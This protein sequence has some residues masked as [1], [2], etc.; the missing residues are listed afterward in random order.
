M[1]SWTQTDTVTGPA[2]LPRTIL[3]LPTQAMILCRTFFLFLLHS[4]PTL[5]TLKWCCSYIHTC[6]KF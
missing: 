2:L 5:S 4:F 1:V 6:C 3:K